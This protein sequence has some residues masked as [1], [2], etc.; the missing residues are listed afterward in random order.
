MINKAK[1][2]LKEYFGYESFRPGQEDIILSILQK[3]EV[4]GILPTGAGKSICYQI[5]ALIFDGLTIVISPL[6]ALMKDQVDNLN[7]KNIKA[8]F[9]NSSLTPS[10]SNRILQDLKSGVYKILYIAPERLAMKKFQEEMKKIDISM[11]AI[12]EAH[13]ISE[14]GHDFRPSYT[15]IKD[16]INNISENK[17]YPAVVALTATATPHVKEDIIK[18]LDFKDPKVFISGFKRE[19][20]ELICIKTKND[21]EKKENLLKLIKS[22]RGSKLIY[23]STRKTA[24]EITLFLRSNN[25]KALCYHGALDSQTR[26]GMQEKFINEKFITMVATN[27]FGMGIDKSDIRLIVHYTMSGSIEAYYQEIG[28]AG[29][30]GKKSSCVLF[31]SPQDRKVH[32]FFVL[33]ENPGVNVI[34]KV[35][36]KV[37]EKSNILDKD[38]V[39]IS[40][41]DIMSSYIYINEMQISASIKILEEQGF[42]SKDMDA[43]SNIKIKLN[44]DFDDII[45]QLSPRARAQKDLLFTLKRDLNLEK[46]GDSQEFSIDEFCLAYNIQRNNI[47]RVLNILDTKGFIKYI[48]P[49]KGR[50]VKILYKDKNIEI[51]TEKINKK[52]KDSI[53]K[54][55]IMEEYILTKMCRHKFIL[56]YFGEESDDD[57][58]DIC[59]NCLYKKI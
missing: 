44:E 9:L 33:S 32:D 54:I 18:Q 17:N 5:P 34:K 52:K 24:E 25:I 15:K 13:C 1:K 41:Y 12:D 6:I 11:I 7:D 43:N 20:L 47:N 31:Y 19:N 22:I 45:K 50:V 53:S 8:T 37:L 39:P 2:T 59:D 35:Y 4:L 30:D 40:N 49:I 28:R 27:A 10:E 46:K 26:K 48:P 56:N 51:D 3:Q 36:L 29:R 14:W 16:S 42:L 38:I 57:Y 21:E 55:N 23:T 58:C